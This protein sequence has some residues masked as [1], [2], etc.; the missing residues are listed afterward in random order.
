VEEVSIVINRD[1]RANNS[2]GRDEFDD[3]FWRA[4]MSN[5]RLPSVMGTVRTEH[6]N[7]IGHD[8][9]L[10]R[11]IVGPSY[12]NFDDVQSMPA[13]KKQDL[14]ETKA[15]RALLNND[16]ARTLAATDLP[17]RLKQLAHILTAI[18]ADFHYSS[19]CSLDRALHGVGN[20]SILPSCKRQ[21][22]FLRESRRSICV[23]EQSRRP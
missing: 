23:A 3:V 7:T 12:G 10:A 4:C 19:R 6:A 17:E 2:L 8:A 13:C 22:P 16:N 21:L 14:G 18:C 20:T 9:Y 1:C 5:A 15:L 11:P